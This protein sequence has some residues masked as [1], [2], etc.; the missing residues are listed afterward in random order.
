MCMHYYYILHKTNGLKHEPLLHSIEKKTLECPKPWTITRFYRK[1]ILW[2]APKPWNAHEPLLHS[3]AN[4]Y[5]EISMNHYCILQ[6]HKH[7]LWLAFFPTTHEHFFW[8]IYA[9]IVR[10]RSSP[11]QRPHPW[12]RAR[13][14]MELSFS[15]TTHDLEK[16]GQTLYLC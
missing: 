16:W 5:T 2:N 13:T 4:K 3:T 9:H 14:C 1:Q 10:P 8:T 6:K 11:R 15:P 12:R 7:F